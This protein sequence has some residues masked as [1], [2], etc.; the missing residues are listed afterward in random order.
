M[1]VSAHAEAA[2]RAAPR[3]AGPALVWAGLLACVPAA[4]VLAL[5][6]GR[7]AIP[8]DTVLA[9]LAGM[10]L[11]LE[12]TWSAV[13]GSVVALVRLPRICLAAVVGAGLGLAGAALQGVYRNP[14]V[15]PQLVGVSSG[16]AFG[17]ALAILVAGGGAVLLGSAF[18][19]GMLALG[20]V[21]WIARIGGRT[22]VLVLV[23]AGVVVSAFFGALVSLLQYVAD[24]D[25]TLPAIVYWLMGSFATATWDRVAAAAVPIALGAALLALMRF[26]INVL[27]LGDEEASALGIAVERSRW[28]VLGAVGLIA[29]AAVAVSGV[30]GW[31]GLVAPHVARMLVGPD[32]RR[33]LPA[34]AL[35]GAAYLI[36]VDTV[37]RA[38][39][40]AEIPLGVLT[41]VV[42]A[43]VFALL[44]RRA[45]ARGWTGD[46]G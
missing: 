33:L 25:T 41:A 22:P 4:A 7:L 18:A 27:S 10:V 40:A 45:A 26:R 13:E 36:V 11:P 37:A 5:G 24:P 38:A 43:P 9:I 23:L 30:V 29:S 12:P 32:H 42:G 6:L 20:V 28:A 15:E 31:V 3:R 16:A 1:A 2:G 19:C 21:H 17:G 46:R 35:L 8:P 34:S 39:T 44:L 14:L